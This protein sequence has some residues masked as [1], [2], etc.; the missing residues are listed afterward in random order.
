MGKNQGNVQG[1]KTAKDHYQCGLNGNV[2][3]MQRKNPDGMDWC[4][5]WLKDT[6]MKRLH[7]AGYEKKR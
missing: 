4:R 1:G 3:P 2:S 5:F 6:P 7:G